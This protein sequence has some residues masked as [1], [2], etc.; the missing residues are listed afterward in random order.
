[1]ERVYQET[2]RPVLNSWLDASGDRSGL[3][4]AYGAS[5]SGKTHTIS[6]PESGGDN[7]GLLPRTLA[8]IFH[9]MAKDSDCDAEEGKAAATAQG[10]GRRVLHMQVAEVYCNVAY[11]LLCDG[12]ELRARELKVQTDS[13]GR[14]R[15]DGLSSHAVEDLE[16]ALEKFRLARSHAETAPTKLNAAS[17]RGHTLWMME[18]KPVSPKGEGKRAGV[19]AIT[20]PRLWIVDMAGSER[21]DRAESDTGE[22][23]HINKDHTAL[24]AC[25]NQMT[26][27]SRF[28]SFRNRT[29]THLLRNMLTR[30]A[31]ASVATATGGTGGGGGKSASP[32]RSSC[33]LVVNVHPGASEYAETHKVL[34]NA[35]L[36]MNVRPNVEV[37]RPVHAF[38][39]NYGYNGHRAGGQVKR[40][41]VEAGNGRAPGTPAVRS[42][43]AGDGTVVRCSTSR[44]EGVSLGRESGVQP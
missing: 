31:G 13:S 34:A 41:R 15:I 44:G 16:S 29:L 2:A 25:L 1:Q 6:G 30:G 20:N 42:S 22:A 33:V 24:F 38:H 37:A 17:S 12:D 7:E 40:Q 10:A 26:L 18:L 28:V 36:A 8:E 4:I 19:S 43:M 39:G 35:A 27:N 21:S 3:I 32:R 14:D 9:T 23:A 11:D 5:G